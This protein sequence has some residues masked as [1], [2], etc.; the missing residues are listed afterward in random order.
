MNSTEL[1]DMFRR[2]VADVVPPYLWSDDEIYAYMNDAYFMFVR[3]TMGI[4]DFLTDEV[5][6]LTATQG[7]P[8]SALHP[9]ILNIRTAT[10]E[11]TGDSIRIINAQ[12]AMNLRQEDYGILRR[13]NQTAV[14][15]KVRYM[16]IGI[17]QDIA[18][19]INTPEEDTAVRLLVERLPITPITGGFQEFEGVQ[20][21]HHLALLKWMRY[22][23][24]SKQDMETF[25]LTRA[26]QQKADFEVYCYSAKREKDKYKHKTRVVMYGG[27]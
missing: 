6:L 3:L 10:I 5:C 4:P 1:Y 9:S 24:Y 7:E 20:Q 21:Q 13:L 8:Y 14:L 19:W 17:Q 12:D 22:L 25:N 11:G 18:Q 16:V 15:G 2:D 23:A 26:D 27:L